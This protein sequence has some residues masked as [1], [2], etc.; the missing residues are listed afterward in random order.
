MLLFILIAFKS[1]FLQSYFNTSHVTVYLHRCLI[2]QILCSIS[3]HLMLLFIYVRKS[4]W[5]IHSHFNTSHV[6][7][8]PDRSPFQPLPDSFQ[9]ISC[10]CLSYWQSDNLHL[11]AFQYIS[12]YCLSRSLQKVL[13]LLENFNT[14]HVTVYLQVFFNVRITCLISIHLMLLFICCLW[15]GS[16]TIYPISIHLML[17]F[18]FFHL[19]CYCMALLISIHLML[20]FISIAGKVREELALFQYISCYCLSNFL[21]YP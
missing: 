3:I 8:Y 18:I 5:D 7:V 9:Y 6:T 19:F 4:S 11:N 16:K 1:S 21:R 13:C 17:L 2:P 15:Q 20:L 14:S 10:Y 12:C